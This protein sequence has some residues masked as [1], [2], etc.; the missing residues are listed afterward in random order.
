MVLYSPPIYTKQTNDLKLR[1]LLSS[2]FDA[3]IYF[4]G[5]YILS[6]CWYTALICI[7]YCNIWKNTFMNLKQNCFNVNRMVKTKGYIKKCTTKL[8]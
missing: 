6:K 8:E 7:Y 4:L 3:L 2:V 1:N 5:H